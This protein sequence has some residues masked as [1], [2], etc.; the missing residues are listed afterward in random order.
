[1][2]INT[3]SVRRWTSPWA[4]GCLLFLA[5]VATAA[6]TVL[7]IKY[8]VDPSVR[9]MLVAVPWLAVGVGV[10]GVLLGGARLWPALFIGSW[11]VWGLIVGD[12]LIPVVVDSAAEAG[13]IVLIVRLLSIWGF[14][15][16]FDR[17]RDPLVLLAAATVGRILATTIDWLGSFAAAWLTPESF[18]PMY[19]TMMTDAG[20]TFPALTPQ[21]F[22]ASVHWTVNCVAG[23]VLVVPLASATRDGLRKT[24]L[25]RPM[26]L[27]ALALALLVWGIAALSLPMLAAA[28]LLVFALMLVAWAAIRFGPPVAA[29]ATSILALVATAGVGMGLGPLAT[30]SPIEYVALQWG[31]VALLA[32]TGLSITALLAE[33]GGALERLTAVAERYQQLFKSNPSPL[34]VAE[35][36]DG[37]ILMVND[38]AMRHY[39]FSELQFLAMT[40]R[41]L[42]VDTGSIGNHAP[43]AGADVG[44]TR[45]LRHR[46]RAGKVIDVELLSTPIELDGHPAMLCYAMDVT[47]R[48]ELRA[49]ILASVTLER[50]RLAQELH[51]GLGQ[52]LTGLSL[53]AEAAAAR[54]SRGKAVDGAFVDFLVDASKQV[55][56]LCRQLTRG[57]SPLHDANGDLL[58]ALRR[59]PESL[60]PGSGPRLEVE[61]ESQGPVSLALERSEHLYR[62]VQ[63][64]VTNV[65]KHANATLLRLRI[66]VTPQIVRIDVEDDGIGIPDAAR[67]ANGLG[68]RSMGMR[69]AAVGASIEVL[70]RPEGGTLI[71]CECPQHER[72][73]TPPA[74]RA[75]PGDTAPE[76]P[77]PSV[78]RITPT[79]SIGP[80]AFVYLGRCLLLAIACFVGVAATFFLAKLIDPRIG[81]SSTRMAI[82]ALAIALSV[83]GLILGG[84][85]LWP[86][87]GLGATVAVTTLSHEPWLLA[88]YYGAE[89][90]LVALIIVELLSQWRFSRAFDHWQ[91]PLSLIGAAIIGGGV[92]GALDFIGL[93]SYQWL[94]PGEMRPALIALMT[95]AAGAT[96]VVTGALLSA[97]ARSCADYIAGVVLF[98]PLLVA[99]PS[100][101]HALRGH[102][103]EVGFWCLGLLGWV[104]CIF[105]LNEV[106]ARLPLVTMALMLLVWA[107]VRFGVAMASAAISVCAVAA[108]LSFALQR[109]VLA[110]ISVNDGINTLWGFLFLLAGIGMSIT[111]LL[112]ERNR[113]VRELTATAQRLRRL[114]ECDPHAL[115][116][117]DDA[118]GRVVMVNEQA[119]RQYGYSEDEWL[120]LTVGKL[121]AN[122][123]SPVTASLNRKHGL[124][125]TRHRL[126]SGAR[127]DVELSYAPI[128]MNG[129]PS[130]LCFAVDVTE[131]N[132]LQRE[133]LEATDLERRRLANEMRLGL[134]SALAEIE[135]AT[136]R[137]EQTAGTAH[138]DS[139]AIDLL[140]RASRRALEVC[141]QTAHNVS[142]TGY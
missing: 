58:E 65:L 3:Q 126:K 107:A 61:I 53:G 42:A 79:P 24:F 56:K 34:W 93:L 104:A 45:S 110:T 30:S 122:P 133:F 99:T 9:I 43:S 113:T 105:V 123:A 90:A 17:F 142:S 54:A 57:V 78:T 96:P 102:R 50:Q 48:L 52:V 108:T 19:R 77:A 55:V 85:R 28:P 82:P 66:G 36:H 140:A 127:I 91:D 18:T 4:A 128:D 89:T 116:V 136:T 12:Q 117:Q 75:V 71:R 51:D 39:G 21:L 23:I 62:L 64:A 38:E 86:G 25:T 119:I 81:V 13:S 88:I 124:V 44:G 95:N 87:V 131:R 73:E 92:V 46:T 101:A 37:R 129:R 11:V 59:L 33:R 63:E 121:A 112:A 94:R 20:G 100:I 5:Y 80:A 22:S 115:W 137:F 10:V 69:A 14:N 41:Q 74:A 40:V 125:E 1:M 135:F 114:F 35:P 72:I 26:S 8:A 111:A 132:T 32:L 139:A 83:A 97:N 2:S 68:M 120:A 7:V 47:E 138:V 76:P 106:D 27:I 98:V 103:A 130:L 15:R 109:G 31:F 141:R 84:K 6:G 49:R 70:A 67:S 16:R 134:G 60:P 118:T 29:F